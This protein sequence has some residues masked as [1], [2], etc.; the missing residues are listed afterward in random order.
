MNIAEHIERGARDF[1]RRIALL[2][3]G[4]EISYRELDEL[5]S[6]AAGAFQAAGVEASDRVALF[7][8][9][10]PEFAI[11]YLG[12]L[13]LGA[14]AVSMNAGLKENEAAFILA[15]SGAKAVITTPELGER[16]R[17]GAVSRVFTVGDDFEAAL[18]SAAPVRSA[19][20][21][22]PNDP[23]AIV[24]TS[25]TTGEPKG[26]TLSHANVVR[27]AEAKR[28]YLGIR[29]ED[30]AL[31]TLP[32][33]HCFGQNAVLNAFLQ[34]GAI[35]VLHRRFDLDQAMRSIARDGVTMF[36][37][38]PAT[39]ILLLDKVARRDM[40][41]VRYYFSAAA[42]LPLEIEERWKEKFGSPIYQG[43]GLTETSP[44]ASYNH[45]TNHRPG[46]IGT[47]I[48]G[49]KIKIVDPATGKDAAPGE[50]GEI[51]IRGHN[52]MLGY[53]NR[54][55]DTAKCIRDGW[56][57]TGDIGSM[58][59][60]GYFFLHDRVTDMIVSGGVNVYPAEVENALAG[61]P[62][63][64]EAAVYGVPEPL[65]GEQ[66]RADIVLK[67][68]ETASEAEIRSFCR[69]RLSPV[70]A[71]A[72]I[73][74]VA[75]IPKNPSGKILKRVL[76]EKAAAEND[77]APRARL[78]VTEGEAERWIR[79]WLRTNLDSPAAFNPGRRTTFADLGMDSI[80][81][82]RLAQELGDWLGL[83]V[84]VAAAWSFPTIEAMARHAAAG[85]G[86]VRSQRT[87]EDTA[88]LSDG[89]AD[90]LLLAELES[91]SR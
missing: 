69:E 8:P 33:Y 63:V 61:H 57:H 32:L 50:K 88:A 44:F 83:K 14:I 2:F 19:K 65:L 18:A 24:Y 47:P 16:I 15:D 30:R 26:A 72:Q 74:F 5:S 64:L 11:A 35:L 56:F 3:E 58:D 12:A 27:N 75:E 10:I 21:M 55:E 71:P 22:A 38:V 84:E 25:G 85:S 79:A 23:A 39:Y 89:A 87:N 78:E 28:R 62:A 6:R 36:F 46:S 20:S 42:S 53:W 66:V 51:A 73:R 80:L 59:E 60:E 81:S 90:A 52:V 9:N 67:A 17:P 29:P 91:I 45:L 31:L 86:S 76:R 40:A 41:G 68:G 70:K 43:Y 82:V 49:V 77:P 4:R 54:P 37:G 13:K 34:V 1:P 7:L 48:D